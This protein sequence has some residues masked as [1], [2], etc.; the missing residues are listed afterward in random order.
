MP[1]TT[2]QQC[3]TC[4]KF[5]ENKR[6]QR[7]QKYCSHFCYT[8]GGLRK[9]FLS[10]FTKTEGCWIWNGCTDKDGYGVMSLTTNHKKRQLR[11][12]RV[13]WMIHHGQDPEDSLVLHT[14]DNRKCVRPDHL[15]L[16]DCKANAQ[17]CTKRGRFFLQRFPEKTPWAKLSYEKAQEIRNQYIKGV[18]G[19]ERLAAEFGVCRRTIQQIVLGKTWRV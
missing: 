16:G 3:P 5:F 14:C 15:Y 7:G 4:G 12:N 11:A 19:Q 8:G 17:D 18:H 1:N 2:K 6:G 13:S 9:R 10:G